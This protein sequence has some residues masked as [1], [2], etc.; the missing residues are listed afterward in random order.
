MEPDMKANGMRQLTREMVVVIKYGQMAP[1][2]K[3]TGA[4]IKLMAEVV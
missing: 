1:C 2:M 3:D 4:M